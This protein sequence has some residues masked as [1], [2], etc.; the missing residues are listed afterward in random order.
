MA[1][2]PHGLN[3][4]NWTDAGPAREHVIELGKQGISQA[5]IIE[6]S[7]VNAMTFRHLV[8]GSHGYPPSQRIM[9]H[10]YRRIMSVTATL[11]NVS[12]GGLVSSAISIRKIRALCAMGWTYSAIGEMLPTPI[13]S[14][15]MGM[16]LKRDR[17]TGQRAREVRDL[18]NQYWDKRPTYR[19]EGHYYRNLRYFERLGYVTAMAWENI[20]DINEP[21]PAPYPLYVR[22]GAK[23]SPGVNDSEIIFLR[24]FG[25]S[26]FQIAKKLGITQKTL[27]ERSYRAS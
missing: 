21:H 2:Q 11:D 8:R 24:A 9:T 19:S 12:D 23:G 16:L 14:S 20:E 1:R 6:L 13:G 10:N 5:R 17:V 7:G 22:K 26:D 27:V 15:N 4:P 18:F 3:S 25:E